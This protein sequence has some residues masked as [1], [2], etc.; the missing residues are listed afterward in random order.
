MYILTVIPIY[1]NKFQEEILCFSKT[2]FSPGT[3]IL[4]PYPQN[5]KKV[6]EKP[7]LVLDSQNVKKQK[8]FLRKTQEEILKCSNSF[9]LKLFSRE[10]LEDIKNKSHKIKKTFIFSLEKVLSIKTTKEI[11]KLKIDSKV[12]II[13]KF[14]DKIDTEFVSKKLRPFLTKKKE[15]IPKRGVHGIADLLGKPAPKK[16]LHS[17]KHY[18]TAE[19]REYFGEKATKGKGSFSFYLGFFKKIPEATIYQFWSEVK[20]SRKSTLSQQKIFW[21]KIGN[22]L[23]KQK[24]KK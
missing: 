19:I 11:N 13:K 1:R 9:T 17:E 10:I 6:Q 24:T 5:S 12:E 22:F 2:E 16:S 8:Q 18:L 21:W 7:A 20:E 14:T 23:K 3:I 15:V 4:I